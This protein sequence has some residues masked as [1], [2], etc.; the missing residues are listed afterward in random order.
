MTSLSEEHERLLRR[1]HS[2]AGVLPLG[3]FF[4]AHLWINARALQGGEAYRRITT[5]LQDLPALL[6]LEVL[7][8]YVPLAFHA[9]YGLWAT[10]ARRPPPPR[11][12]GDKPWAAMMQRFT[13]ALTLC[14]LVV[15]FWQFRVQVAVDRVRPADFFP[16]LCD[17]L[18]STTGLGI[19]VTAGIYLAGL[20]AASYHFGSGV[21]GF[22]FTF[23]FVRAE[24]RARLLSACCVGLALATFVV[25]ADTVF[26]F[27]TGASWPGSGEPTVPQN[28]VGTIRMGLDSPN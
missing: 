19:P 20:A 1:V 11:G 5:R 26:T 18:S 9:G 3:A 12:P 27:A 7:F 16:L 2:A 10:F 24:S 4:L 15:H 13:G 28:D 21:L 8:V 6:A 23:G 14:F 25:G 17:R 22:C